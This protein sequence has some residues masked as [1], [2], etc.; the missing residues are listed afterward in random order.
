[1]K[2][3]LVLILLYATQS[4]ALGL[5]DFIKSYQANSPKLSQLNAELENAQ[6][7]YKLAWSALYPQ[8]SLNGSYVDNVSPASSLGFVLPGTTELKSKNYTATINLDQVIY[9]GGKIINNI[10]LQKTRAEISGLNYQTQKQVLTRDAL[11]MVIRWKFMADTIGVLNESLK[12]QKRFLKLVNRRVRSGLAKPFEYDQAFSDKMAYELRIE[13]LKQQRE[14]LKQT[15]MTITD[16][17][18]AQLAS[19][20]LPEAKSLKIDTS[21]SLSVEKNWEYR[22]AVAEEKIIDE[23]LALEMSDERPSLTVG[24]SIGRQGPKFDSLSE[25]ES[26]ISQIYVNLKVPLF[27]GFSSVKKRSKSKTKRFSLEKKKKDIMRTV[28]VN[29]KQLT[30]RLYKNKKLLE[31]NL[32][33]QRTSKRGL[34]RALSSYNS[35]QVESV[36]VVQ[37]QAVY[38]RA[39]V[40]YLDLYELYFKDYIDW[41]FTQGNNIEEIF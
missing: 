2:I 40:S 32:L 16:L 39:A 21:G 13:Q 34:K 33:W 31:K 23:Q 36:Q 26:K 25:R 27:T 15:L 17:T 11:V 1:M 5:N 35:G 14:S 41:N 28:K 12:L 9:A 20:V 37:M 22:G 38:E 19:L 24:G 6:Q 10:K 29:S 18:E 8:I 30:D 3:F 7:N 4:N